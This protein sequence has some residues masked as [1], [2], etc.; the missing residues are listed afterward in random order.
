MSLTEAQTQALLNG[1]AAEPPPG[2]V[3]N[4]V[5][6]PSD[7]YAGTVISILT[8][9]LCTL[10]LVLRMLTKAFLMRQIHGA[11]CKFTEYVFAVTLLIHSRRP[12]DCLG[13]YPWQVDIHV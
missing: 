1:P 11:D 9:V 3:P 13:M 7:L 12:S 2:I 4:L 10:A 6:P 8:L 5:D